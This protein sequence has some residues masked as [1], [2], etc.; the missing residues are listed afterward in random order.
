MTHTKKNYIYRWHEGGGSIKHKGRE[1]Q[2]LH[3]HCLHCPEL[4]QQLV[5]HRRSKRLL[6]WSQ[7]YKRHLQRVNPKLSVGQ[8]WSRETWNMS[9]YVWLSGY[10]L[11]KALR[12][13]CH[14]NTL[15]QDPS[16]TMST[17]GGQSICNFPCKLPA[18]QEQNK[19]MFWD[20]AGNFSCTSS[21]PGADN[22]LLQPHF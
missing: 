16:I 2:K 12:S 4:G 10:L 1:Q 13:K 8:S 18:P 14:Q 21:F 11:T 3:K 19:K 22:N 6:K 9:A 5:T 20:L 17:W 7:G 15:L